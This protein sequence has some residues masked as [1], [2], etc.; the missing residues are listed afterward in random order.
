MSLE[1]EKSMRILNDLVSYCYYEGAE[2][3]EMGIKHNSAEDSIQMRVAC[4][5]EGLDTGKVEEMRKMLSLPRQGEVEQNYWELSGETEFGGELS[6]VGAMSDKAEVS[7]EDGVLRVTI[8]RK[9]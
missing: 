5:I 4:P 3:F 1:L 9:A 2:E 6:L 7:Y 8:L